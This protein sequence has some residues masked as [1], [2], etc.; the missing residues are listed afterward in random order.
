MKS[1][2]AVQAIIILLLVASAASCEVGKEYTARVFKPL[3]QKKSDTATLRFMG[4]DSDNA[5]DS[6]DLKDFVNKEIKEDYTTEM[7]KDTI[8]TDITTT[9]TR[10]FI[11]EKPA[12]G[13]KRGTT[14]T[15]RMRQ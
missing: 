14:R 4:F 2:G 9:E 11:A 3:P 6:I 1:A 13:V 5:A 12:E 8:K 15:K 10:K 7:P